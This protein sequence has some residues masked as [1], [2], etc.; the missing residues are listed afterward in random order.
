MQTRRYLEKKSTVLG[1]PMQEVGILSLLFMTMTVIGSV[2]KLFFPG[3][4]AWNH[5]SFIV[6]AAGFTIL[7]IPAS[8]RHPS[9]LVS[10]ISYYFL[11][12]N[13]SFQPGQ[14]RIIP[15]RTGYEKEKKH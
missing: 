7:R 11:Q 2:I 5:F 13:K 1:L 10:A 8:K 4:T 15:N 12:K 9:F 14:S 3:I 6:V